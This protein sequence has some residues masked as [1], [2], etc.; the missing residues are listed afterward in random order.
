MSESVNVSV[1]LKMKKKPKPIKLAS[2]KTG[3]DFAF[4]SETEEKAQLAVKP[5]WHISNQCG[6]KWFNVTWH[7]FK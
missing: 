5:R 1:S 6:A 2:D 7:N 3:L 4:K